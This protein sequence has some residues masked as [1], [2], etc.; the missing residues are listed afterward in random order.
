MSTTSLQ[1]RSVNLFLG[2]LPSRTDAGPRPR[3][4]KSCLV[5][6]EPSRDA[7]AQQLVLV[8]SRWSST[9]LVRHLRSW[10]LV[11]CQQLA[12]DLM[13]HGG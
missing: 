8:G 10:P 2:S 6:Q 7:C 3:S 12:K 13:F 9:L 1:L 5:S 11:P 4:G